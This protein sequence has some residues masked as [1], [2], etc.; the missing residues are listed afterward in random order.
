MKLI[1][2]KVIISL[3]C[4]G[5][6]GMKK[7]LAFFTVLMLLVLSAMPA[8][9]V[10]ELQEIDAPYG[11]VY[12]VYND[13]EAERVSISCLFTDEY[14]SIS[15]MTNAESYAAYGITDIYTYVQIDYKIDGGDWHHSEVWE[16]TPDAAKYGGQVPKGDTVRVF[17]LLYLINESTREDAGSLAKTNERG[18]YVFD[19]D[20]HTLEFRMRTTMGY[21][22]KNNVGQVTTSAWTET[23]KVERDA[24]FGESPKELEAPYAYEPRVEYGDDEMPYLAF[25]IRT[26]ES[27]KES[28]AWLATQAPTYIQLLVEID[29]GDG[30]WEEQ[31]SY[32]YDSHLA[33]ESKLIYLSAT[34]LDDASDMRVRAR[35]VTYIETENGTQALY[36]EY[37]DE[38][39]FSVPRWKEGKGILHARCS[40]CAICHPI[41]GQCMFVLGGILLVVLAIAAIPLKMYLDKVKKRKAAEEAEKQRKL[42]EER[43]ALEKA[44]LEKKNKNKKQNR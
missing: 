1:E 18:K 39:S 9:A 17:D 30:T 19:L 16:T 11:V 14:A 32:V 7:T 26:P 10:M 44:K 40:V 8:S 24:D 42:E 27:V 28:G 2:K 20:N 21:M 25:D 22:T 41:A 31:S 29:R 43:K 33:N 4:F 36:S 23:I 35:Y 38:L 3:Y 12:K 6:K 15:D 5:G 34:D 13:T 37:S